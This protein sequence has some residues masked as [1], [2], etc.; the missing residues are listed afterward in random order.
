[1]VI[2]EEDMIVAQVDVMK[3]NLLKEIDGYL[4]QM[5]YLKD[6]ISVK[7]DLQNCK[8]K[9]QHVPNFTLIVECALTDSYMLLLMRLFEKS[10]KTKTIPNLIDKCMKNTHLFPDPKEAAE[11][12]EEFQSK[13]EN[14]EFINHAINTL[15]DRR[16]TMH[17]HNDKKFFGWKLKKDTSYLKEYHI[18]FL[19]MLT[20]E[21]LTYLFEQL[22]SE[23]IRKPMYNKELSKWLL[24]E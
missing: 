13:I 18:W 16:D 5:V 23:E 21:L 22:S 11:R 15:K 20:E 12:L 17:A 24:G 19:V 2:F 3:E 14:D 7:E 10:E 1:M 6:L 8:K 4:M 9:M